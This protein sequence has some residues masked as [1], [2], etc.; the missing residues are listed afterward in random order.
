M[1]RGRINIPKDKIYEFVGSPKEMGI[2]K[3][4]E[5]GSSSKVG[6]YEV[7]FGYPSKMRGYATLMSDIPKISKNHSLNS[8]GNLKLTVGL[9]A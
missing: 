6:I 7:S 4:G 8:F 9:F 2:R 3:I 5:I 1:Q